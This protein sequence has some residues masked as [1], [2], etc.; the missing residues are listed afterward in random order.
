VD[1]DTNWAKI[2]IVSKASDAIHNGGATGTADYPVRPTTKLENF[3]SIVAANGTYK[4]FAPLTIATL[5]G[6][7]VTLVLTNSF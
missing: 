5:D 1:C 6:E 2:H 7:P 4:F 3:F